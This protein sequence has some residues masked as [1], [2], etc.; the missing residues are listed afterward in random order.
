MSLLL[1]GGLALAGGIMGAIGTDQQSRARRRELEQQKDMAWSQYLLGQRQANTQFSLQ[2]GEAMGQAAIAERRLGESLDQSVTQMN[3]GLLGQAYGIQDAQIRASQDIGAS[4]A[5]EGASGTR[6]G[7]GGGLMRAYT[8]QSLDRNIDL[9][10]RENQQQLAGMASQAANAFQDFNRER[11]SWVSG[12]YRYESQQAQD[13][14][15]RDMA[16]LGQTNFNYQMEN[17]AATDYDKF[18]GIFSGASSGLSLGASFN[19]FWNVS[20]ASP[21]GSQYT[22]GGMST[23]WRL[24]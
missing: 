22:A 24:R 20:G 21:K 13:A 11:A 7:S 23:D 15:N 14:Y 4:L 19:S 8:Q 9:Q 10:N 18:M 6:G 17:A 5:A 1:L 12:G 16:K 3:T 2:R